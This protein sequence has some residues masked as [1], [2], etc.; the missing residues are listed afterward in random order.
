MNDPHEKYDQFQCLRELEWGAEIKGWGSV[1]AFCMH[2]VYDQS[3]EH[4]AT[5]LTTSPHSSSKQDPRV[6]LT[7][8]LGSTLGRATHFASAAHHFPPS[9][10]DSCP[11]FDY[12]HPK[13][14][15]KQNRKGRIQIGSIASFFNSQRNLINML[16]LLP[17]KFQI[18][19]LLDLMERWG[20]TGTIL[21]SFIPAQSP[22]ANSEEQ[23][24][25]AC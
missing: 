23:P 9:W 15:Q 16:F 11:T 2:T 4:N 22:P 13:R 5:P 18:W 20:Q 14:Q 7:A 8:Q 10:D 24:E 21:S 6:G 3:L 19:K 25:P 12:P 17:S 1:L